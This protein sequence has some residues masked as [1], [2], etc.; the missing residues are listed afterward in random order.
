MAKIRKAPSY[1][2]R[3]GT[4]YHFRYRISR[5]Y[6]KFVSGEVR[7]SLGT[8]S[9]KVAR[10]KAANLI[11]LTE[12]YLSILAENGA[13]VEKKEEIKRALARYLREQLD[14]SELGRLDGPDQPGEIIGTGQKVKPEFINAIIDMDVTDRLRHREG[15]SEIDVNEFLEMAG[16]SDIP[17]DSISYKYAQRELLKVRQAIVK[18]ENERIHGRYNTLVETSILSNYPLQDQTAPAPAS[19]IS[20]KPKPKRRSKRLSKAIE[21]FVNENIAD[22]NWAPRSI[23]GYKERLA[24]LPEVMGDCLLSE[25][26]HKKTRKFFDDIRQLPPNRNKVKAYRGRTVDQL[27]KMKLPPEKCISEKTVKNIMQSVYALFDW[28]VQRDLME[29][30]YASGMKIK[31]NKRPDEARESFKPDDLKILFGTLTTKD[32]HKFWIPLIG[33]YTGARLEEICQLHIGD[34]RQDEG[35]W[36]I[37][38]NDNDQKRLKNKSSR[39]IVPVHKTLIEKGL[40]E[41]VHKMASMGHERLFPELKRQNGKYGHH[42]P[43]VFSGLL[44][45]LNIKTEDR[46]VS[47]HSLRHTFATKAKYMGL[48]EHHIGEILGHSHNTITYGTY[49]KRFGAI[50]LKEI[51]DQMDFDIDGPMKD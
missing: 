48:P 30:N 7:L 27:L 42:F 49:G 12:N 22:N 37:D 24:N 4:V 36:V 33:L 28:A 23:A 50:E 18:I 38:I 41:Y 31:Q 17:E 35:I 2:L 25:I 1:L 51:I 32:G 47:F 11:S 14:K 45:K 46:K 5:Q 6:Q 40:I 8:G 10:I 21:E 16:L 43:R 39:R 44:E 20:E 26:D 13:M 15:W 34:I 9:L 19:A 29:K 3:V